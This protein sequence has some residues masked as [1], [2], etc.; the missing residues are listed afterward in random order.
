MAYFM[1]TKAAAAT[2]I[3]TTIT[4]TKLDEKDQDIKNLVYIGGSCVSTASV[5]KLRTQPLPPGYRI[6]II[7]PHSHFHYMFGFPRASVH[8][9]F[10]QELFA[11]Y[12]QMFKSPDVGLTIQAGAASITKTHV[13]LDREVPGFGRKVPYAY[14]VYAAGARHPQPGNLNDYNSKSEGISALQSY[15][16]RIKAAA[17]IVIVGAGAVGLELASEIKEA[18]PEKEVTL[19]HSR[20]RYMDGYKVGLHK[21]CYAV[22]K[23]YGVNQILG[24]RVVVPEGGFVHDGQ[25]RKIVTRSGMEIES[26]LQILCT[27]MTPNSE[28]LATLSPASV[29][30][31]NK[32]VKIKPTFQ[33]ADESYP[34]VFAGGD[35]TDCDDIKTGLS[36]FW[37][38]EVIVQ[39]LLKL[40]AGETDNTNLAV[41]KPVVPQIILYLGKAYAVTQLKF[42][43]M[44]LTLKLGPFFTKRFLTENLGAARVWEWCGTPLTKDSAAS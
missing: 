11:P 10:E 34:N 4:S 14:L 20:Q 40:V 36:A 39:N 17:K 28:V 37:H 5:L 9:G 41:R 29:N 24:E 8:D 16:Q 43:G 42:F 26:D 2:A 7:E 19:I 13:I 6:I 15:Q 30:P 27:G 1:D 33:I 35:V 25:L 23:K 3:V 18:Y 12:N 38:A 21:K 44:V 31:H 22:L 32:L